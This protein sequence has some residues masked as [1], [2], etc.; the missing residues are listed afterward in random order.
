MPVTIHIEAETAEEAQRQMRALV[1]MHGVPALP[2][3]GPMPA[4]TPRRGRKPKAP[5]SQDMSGDE[6]NRPDR[7]DPLADAGDEPSAPEPQPE[8]AKESE[9][10][11]K[12]LVLLQ[13]AYGRPGGAALVKELQ[14]KYGVARFAEVPADMHAELLADATEL[15][16]KV[17]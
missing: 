1:W 10:Q 14:R 8:P 9:E 5:P 7:A 15:S 16:K 12:A 11:K 3:Q 4:E 17:A 6:E 13:R 2:S